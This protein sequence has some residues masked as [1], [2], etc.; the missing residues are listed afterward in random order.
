MINGN[1]GLLG[2]RPNPFGFRCRKASSSWRSVGR[3]SDLVDLL[4][5]GFDERHGQCFL[6]VC[7]PVPCL[8]IAK[9][10]FR[11]LLALIAERR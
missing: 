9:A 6:A 10:G 11:Q 1:F 7:P 5:E 4:L 2:M 3:P 8:S